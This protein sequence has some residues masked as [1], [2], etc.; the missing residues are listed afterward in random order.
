[1][2]PGPNSQLMSIKKYHN[3]GLLKLSIL[4][5]C[6]CVD[7]RLDTGIRITMHHKQ[8]GKRCKPAYAITH[9]GSHVHYQCS[10]MEKSRQ[11]CIFISFYKFIIY[12]PTE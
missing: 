4:C 6:V 5:L 7:T 3:S 2:V 9:I 8:R 10:W 1:M 12:H 11:A